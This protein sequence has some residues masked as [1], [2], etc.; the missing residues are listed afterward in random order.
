LDSSIVDGSMKAPALL[1]ALA[2]SVGEELR[3]EDLL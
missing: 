2:D 1:E 3:I